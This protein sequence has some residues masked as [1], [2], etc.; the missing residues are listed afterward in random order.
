MDYYGD[1][2]PPKRSAVSPQ[3]YL[4]ALL[5]S[6]G[7]STQRHAALDTAYFN[8]PTPLQQ[9]SFHTHLLDLI[10]RGD[11]EAL[12][13]HLLCG[14]STNPANARGES[15]VHRVCRVGR[16]RL[17]DTLLRDVN[18][19][20]RVADHQGRTPLHEACAA[21]SIECV[22]LLLEEDLRLLHVADCDNV[23]P[24]QLVPQSAWADWV[25]WLDGQQDEYWPEHNPQFNSGGGRRGRQ[26]CEPPPLFALQAPDSR[27]LKDPP[28]ALTLDVAAR[29][30][31]GQVKP[32]DAQHE[33]KRCL[34]AVRDGS[35]ASSSSSQYLANIVPR[36]LVHNMEEESDLESEL[37][38]SQV[39]LL[40][41]DDDRT[42]DSYNSDYDD[43]DES[44]ESA[45]QEELNASMDLQGLEQAMGVLGIAPMNPLRPP[46]VVQMS[47]RLE[48]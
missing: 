17:L 44:V 42:P 26:C 34:E 37:T 5:Y 47:E 23:V 3:E 35:S 41:D 1:E 13:A 36:K 18:V 45:G 25:Q 8:R 4:D 38:E 24:L 16:S 6:R 40:L 32:E 31:S 33:M 48:Y 14:L 28:N 19:D 21:N 29:V 39:G 43:N 46:P 9:A 7:Y 20:V 11:G 30:A 12:R 22:E 2:S 15:I 10:R 27:P